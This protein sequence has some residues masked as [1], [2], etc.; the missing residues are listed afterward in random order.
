MSWHYA[1]VGFALLPFL[2]VSNR[3]RLI[4]AALLLVVPDIVLRLVPSLQAAARVRL[5]QRDA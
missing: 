5:P 3:T 4:A 1:V 2:R